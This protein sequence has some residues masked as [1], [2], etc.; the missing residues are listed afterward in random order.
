ME[1]FPCSHILKIKTKYLKFYLN[2]THAVILSCY[3]AERFQDDS[4]QAYHHEFK[5]KGK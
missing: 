3:Y 5:T 2:V 4:Q 1:T